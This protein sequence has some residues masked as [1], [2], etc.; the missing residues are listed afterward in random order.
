MKQFDISNDEFLTL[1]GEIWFDNFAF[2]KDRIESAIKRKIGNLDEFIFD[3][4]F[5]RRTKYT[6]HLQQVKGNYLVGYHGNKDN[7][8]NCKVTCHMFTFENTMFLYGKWLE[9]YKDSVWYCTL[10]LTSRET[11]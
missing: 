1:D 10:D 4:T 5:Q 7:K 2:N 6:V 3:F 11:Y 8:D 9:D